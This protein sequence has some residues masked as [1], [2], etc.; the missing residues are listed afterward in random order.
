MI[1]AL[2]GETVAKGLQQ[3]ID[4]DFPC[5]RLVVEPRPRI[6]KRCAYR[7]G[8]AATA[9]PGKLVRERTCLVV[10]AAKT[11]RRRDVSDP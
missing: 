7:F 9:A 6:L 1:E 10:L 3:S 8:H 4:L 11:R 2:T 5:C